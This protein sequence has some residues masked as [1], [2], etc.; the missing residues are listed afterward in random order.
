MPLARHITGQPRIGT[1]NQNVRLKNVLRIYTAQFMVEKR[2]DTSQEPLVGQEIFESITSAGEVP[3]KTQYKTALNSLLLQNPKCLLELLDDP[4]YQ[5][6]FDDSEY[7]EY[8]DTRLK[9][10][11]NG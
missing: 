4:E 8:L 3:S 11:L 9:E 10:L 5:W 1:P 6:I 2:T 7:V